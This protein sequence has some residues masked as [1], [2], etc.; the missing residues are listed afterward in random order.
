MIAFC[1]YKFTNLCYTIIIR[2][3][4]P[5]RNIRISVRFDIFHEVT[6]NRSLNEQTYNNKYSAKALFFGSLAYALILAYF[7]VVLFSRLDAMA[8]EAVS[9]V[10][11][12]LTAFAIV[13]LAGNARPLLSLI[14]PAAIFFLFG[15]SFSLVAFVFSLIGSVTI[16]ACL[17][18]KSSSFAAKVFPLLL[19]AA[20]YLGTALLVGGFILPLICFALLPAGLILAYCLSKEISRVGTVCRVS[21]GLLLPAAAALLAWVFIKHGGNFSVI[22]S[23]IE[24]TRLSLTEKLG[25]TLVQ[26][27]MLEISVDTDTMSDLAV[28]LF[29]NLLP[30]I[31]ITTANLLAFMLQAFTANLL[32]VDEN[33]KERLM[34]LYGFKM[35]TASAVVFLVFLILY[36]VFSYEAEPRL[37]MAAFNVTIILI[38]G[39]VYTALIWIKR[40]T[41]SPNASCFSVLIY[42]GAIMLLIRYTYYAA[43]GG[44]M[45][46]A[47]LLIIDAAKRAIAEHKNQQKH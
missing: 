12:V 34:T 5:Y 46:G 43:I 4:I 14:T 41:H 2:G 10:A 35:S 37:A 29:F 15:G 8:T 1:V 40:L 28:S 6:V 42:F 13:K 31:V 20:V 24:N 32:S 25:E 9:I 30:A 45:I 38:P 36:A 7:P 47:A 27:E 18:Y 16:L 17:I 33:D 39:L 23:V 22:P 26:L 11:I 21:F 44:A 19:T 3:G